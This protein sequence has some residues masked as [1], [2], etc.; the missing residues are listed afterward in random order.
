M[1]TYFNYL[2]LLI[3]H[4]YFWWMPSYCIYLVH[5]LVLVYDSTLPSYTVAISHSLGIKQI[6]TCKHSWYEE[7]G[8]LFS[9][10]WLQPF[11]PWS[12][13]GVRSKMERI[14][15]HTAWSTVIHSRQKPVSNFLVCN[16]ICIASAAI[17]KAVWVTCT[18]TALAFVCVVLFEMPIVQLEKLL[19][20][21]CGISNLPQIIKIKKK[22][23]TEFI[24]RIR[25]QYYSR[26]RLH[27][28][29][30]LDRIKTIW[31][32]RILNQTFIYCAQLNSMNENSQ[33]VQSQGA[34]MRVQVNQ[35]FSFKD[36]KDCEIRNHAQQS[37][38]IF[39]YSQLNILN[40]FG[41]F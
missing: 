18:S 24:L 10:D 28:W 19:Y 8:S 20:A 41:I 7:F 37:V 30:A 15:R 5:I 31:K 33:M 40:A 36:C 1:K 32:I 27:L 35:L 6:L 13:A 3:F 4:M 12:M 2:N 11:K 26:R 25:R 34:S 14:F 29:T 38:N 17:Y 16:N 23:W 39:F 9:W 21:S 22:E